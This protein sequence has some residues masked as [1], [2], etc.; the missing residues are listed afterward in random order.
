M[1]CLVGP[2]ASGKTEAALQLAEKER[3]ELISVDSMQVYRGMDIGTAKA[4]PELRARFKLIDVIDPGQKWSV[5]EFCKAALPLIENAW[6]EGKKPCLVGG[7]GLYYEGLLRG[8][9]DIPDIPSQLRADIDNLRSEGHHKLLE[10]LQAEDP[11]S[12]AKIDLNNP[13]RVARAL[14]VMRHT[15]KS[16]QDWQ[17]ETHPIIVPSKTSWLGLDPGVLELD[18]KIE[19]RCEQMMTHGWPDEAAALV[20]KHGK[21][22]VLGTGAIGYAQALE[23]KEGY[24]D[25]A[26]AIEKVTILTRQY[27]RRQRTWFKKKYPIEWH[28]N[29]SSL[30]FL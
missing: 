16:L 29:A 27:A 9:A 1:I 14:E 5:G 7:T 6:A 4:S 18:E 30:S 2:T 17:K 11:I 23:V 24:L 10:A 12:A 8:L 22:A 25:M 13:Q 28:L 3:L 20:E 26:A 19:A 21:D 15:G